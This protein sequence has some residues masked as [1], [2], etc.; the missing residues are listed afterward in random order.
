[1]G[2]FRRLSEVVI[3]RPEVGVAFSR[4]SSES[5]SILERSVLGHAYLAEKKVSPFSSHVLCSAGYRE[6][7]ETDSIVVEL[8]STQVLRVRSTCRPDSNDTKLH[9]GHSGVASRTFSASQS[10][11]ESTET[12]S[13]EISFD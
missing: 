6:P 13:A 3:D 8:L 9:G 11:A 7:E 4:E 2:R 1:M 5:R 12:L 10:T